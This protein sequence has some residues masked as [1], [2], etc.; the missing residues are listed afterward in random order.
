MH[1]MNTNHGP[2]MFLIQDASI[3]ALSHFADDGKNSKFFLQ[4]PDL[5]LRQSAKQS[6]L[7]HDLG[8]ESRPSN[9]ECG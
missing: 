1:S 9:A 8:I 3:S 2:P 4:Y 6:Y 7:S 5:A